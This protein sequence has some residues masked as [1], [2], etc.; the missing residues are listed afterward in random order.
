MFTKKYQLLRKSISLFS[1]CLLLVQSL[2][3]GLA[4]I[5]QAIATNV[6]AQET[7]PAETQTPSPTDTVTPTET[8]TPAPTVEASPIT[9]PENTP[10]P[11]NEPTPT[12]VAEV[13][14][15]PTL[16]DT[17]IV[18]PTET[19]TPTQSSE[20]PKNNSPPSQDNTQGDILDGVSATATP[21]HIPSPTPTPEP[22]TPAALSAAILE[23]V[24]V[25]SLDLDN[26]DSASSASLSTD[27]ADYAPTDAALITG[28]GL[29]KNTTYALTIKSDDAPATSTTVNV[30]TD[31]DG[32]FVYAYQLD[33]IYRPNYSVYLYQSGALVAQTTFTDSVTV[34]A[35]TGGTNIPSSK[36]QNGPSPAYTTLGNIVITEQVDTDFSQNQTNSTLI[37]T[38]P[39][40]WTFNPGIGSVSFAGTSPGSADLI[41]ATVSVTSGVI[42][43][44]FST[45]SNANKSDV[46]TI[47]GIQVRAV[48]GTIIPANGNIFRTVGNPGT[49]VIAGITNGAT[50]FGA[51]SQAAVSTPTNTPTPTVTPT[52]TNTPTPTPSGATPTPTPSSSGPIAVQSLACMADQPTAPNGLTCTANDID[53][54]SV[55]NIQIVESSDDG[56]NFSPTTAT[57]CEYPGQYIKFTASWHV[58]S[59]ATSRYNVGLWFANSGQTSALH[60]TC[61]ASTLP[62]SPSPFFEGSGDICGDINSGATGTVTPAI[63]VVAR[64]VAAPGTNQLSLPYC[65]SWDNNTQ[66]AACT[67][68]AGTVAGTPSKCNCN[69]GFTIPIVVPPAIEVIKHISP[70]ND[71]G[72]FNLQVNSSTKKANATHLDTTGKVGV[73]AGSNTFGET[74]GTGTDLSNYTSSAS[75]V[76]RGTQTSVAASIN[77]NTWTIANVANGQDIVCTITNTRVNNGSITIIKDASPNSAQDFAFTTTGTGLS[78]FNLDDDSD[79]TLSNTK[80]FSSLS[81]GNYSITESATTGWS[82]SSLS[83]V[84]NTTQQAV[85]TLNGAV[86]SIAL[87]SGQNVTCTYTN[88]QDTATIQVI[89]NVSPTTD[90]GV[91]NLRID[92]VTQA[93]NVGH[94]GDTGALTVLTT[95]THTV[96]ETA[97]TD[98]LL[99][100]YTTT[101]VCNNNLSGS[102]TSVGPFSVTKDQAVVCTFTNTRNTGSVKV[103]KLADT[104]G[105]GSFETSNPQSFTWSLDGA[106]TNAMGASVSGVTTGTH[107]VNENSVTD[108]HFVGWY[109]TGSTQYSCANPQ[110]TTLPISVTVSSTQT[111]EI[112]LCNARD[113]GTLRV[114]KNVDLNGD[115]D[116]TDQGE[117]GAT[118]WEW[119]A[120]TSTFTGMTGDTAITVPTGTYALTETM[121]SNFHF[122]SLQC[123]G[124]TLTD[125]SVA[126][127]T[128]ATVV[129]TFTN[130]RDTGTIQVVKDVDPNDSGATGWNFSISGATANTANDLQD[131]ESS[132]VFTSMTGA[133]TITESAHTGTNADHYDTTYSCVDGDLVV[134]TGSGMTTSEF[135]LQTGKNIVCTFTNT[136]K[137]GTIIVEKQMVGGTGSAQ[138]T[139]D[140]AG[141][142]VTNGGEIQTSNILPGTYTSVESAMTGWD[143]TALSCDDGRSTTP[144][145]TDIQTRTATFKVDPGETIVCTFTNTKRG[146]L[147]VYKFTD[148]QTDTTTAFDITATGSGT[149][150]APA[151]RT[152]TGG[153]S[154]VYEVTPGSY[155][156]SESVE[157][158]WAQTGNTCVNV[159][160][161]AGASESCTITNTKL[162][163]VTVVKYHDENADGVMNGAEATL[164]DWEMV[165]N[166]TMNQWTG[167]QNEGQ[168]TFS[169]LMPGNYTLSESLQDGWYQSNIACGQET[170]TDADNSHTVVLGAGE[171]ITC[172]VGNYQSGSIVVTKR[173]VN[174]DGGEVVDTST[175]FPFA[176][177]G[178]SDTPTL[179]DDESHTFVVAPGLHTVTETT[180]ENYDF[181]GCSEGIAGDTFAGTTVTVTSGQTVNVDCTNKQKKAT[182]TVVKDVVKYDGSTVDDTHEFE[183]TLDGIA[184][185][186][187][188][189]SNAVY[190]VNPGTYSGIESADPAYTLVTN[191][192]PATVSS[193]GTATI[194]IVNR[195]N[196]GTISGYKFKADGVTA[197]ANWLVELWSCASDFTG[198]VLGD[199]TT[200]NENGFYSFTNLVTGFYKV[201]EELVNTYTPVGVTEYDQQISPGTVSEN[202]NFANFKNID[203]TACKVKDADADL[204]TTQDQTTVS[205][206][207]MTL[208]VDGVAQETSYPTGKDG[209]YT[210]ENLGPDH[211]YGVSEESRSGWAALGDTSV[212]FGEPEDGVNESHTFYNTELGS[213]H[214]MKWHDINGNGQQDEI[215]TVLS[216]WMINLYKDN[217]ESYEL[218]D[219]M[220]TDSGVDHYGW[221]WFEDLYPGKYRVCEENQ[222]GWSQT[223]PT[224]NNGC[225]DVTLPDG[226]SGGFPEVQNATFGATY[227]FGNQE[228]G[229][230]RVYKYDDV[231]GNGQ[232][233]EGEEYLSGWE[234]NLSDGESQT[235]Q[236]T[237]EDGFTDF[238]DLVPG[239]YV[240]SETLEQGWNQ[241]GIS[242]QSNQTRID[243]DSQLTLGV[244]RVHA[245]EETNSENIDL[246]ASETVTCEVGNQYIQPK[247]L[248]E[249]TNNAAGDKAPGSDVQFTLTI[250]A[251]DNDVLGVSVRDLPSKGFAYRSG[252]WSAKKNGVPFAVSEPTYASPGT[253]TLGDMNVNDVIELIYT[254]DIAT[255]Q[256]SGTYRDLAWAAGTNVLSDEVVAND[257][258]GVFV[259]TDVTV[260]RGNDASTGVNVVTEKTGEVLG[261]STELPSTGASQ[262]WLGVSGIGLM[263][264][265]ASML[266]GASLNK[267][268]KKGKR[269][270]HA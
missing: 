136:L 96:S 48:D 110:G 84:D 171:N 208:I 119:Q 6:Q 144:S 12:P 138:F 173:V 33:G 268:A 40:N 26:V 182:I 179:T 219:T 201:M 178:S 129:C 36:A 256:Q 186:F 125:N 121:K 240:L 103:N 147:T 213:I 78:S 259:G 32:A 252:S 258:T 41:L 27:K 130:A 190:S 113:T 76:L 168:V 157:A 233:D 126:V 30:T 188:E 83:C 65:T 123:T 234:M 90:P 38:A 216:G 22:E 5:P 1:G 39:S 133:Y 148:P 221:Y 243:R 115:G 100:D 251:V 248:I 167:A 231:N 249:K 120:N 235:T 267:P 80:V 180:N 95:A 93:A 74:A 135:A 44:T 46:M 102:G 63:T 16:T 37:L 255:D 172:Y 14:V 222:S 25:T 54:A 141:T 181:V 193:N 244:T 122:V 156:I 223:Y 183:V 241:T 264:G 104:D 214:G 53:I 114:L 118:N 238:E 18:T 158:G 155:W 195:Q 88:T 105:N 203:I 28:T 262:F 61:S 69:D 220:D 160:V 94:G 15:T 8:T 66:T 261:A 68:P 60:G 254:A 117:T 150:T 31:T 55:D 70:T 137:R 77:A 207:D 217:G 149:I 87:T 4:A 72:L 49:G 204:E 86:A 154:Q 107:S 159:S 99:S 19:V 218:V 198:C 151:G 10:S 230:I 245:Q 52:S 11:T 226:N 79:N 81:S 162:G 175:E 166:G 34:T 229:M 7:T 199:S 236:T 58:L 225:H 73:I 29:K 75:C 127:T 187:A 247:L 2:L 134:A 232:K 194:T 205:S 21:T 209:C 161:A 13:S 202:N 24:E 50:S 82:L 132:S 263:L 112:T 97:G 270:L 177:G 111:T 140:V 51:L 20:P 62:T 228:H 169:D 152:I 212:S 89:K 67:G 192:S 185:P 139:G 165:L 191:D 35:A 210:W 143:L 17:P 56:V 124:G 253:W 59:N 108:Y 242:C 42:T 211:T 227:N 71:P 257:E 260:V 45:D 98:T 265:I 91:F 163:N 170:G 269:K 101:Y 184:K 23:H 153:S 9:T 174:P 215:G 3:P 197:I 116:Y 142:I 224:L 109:P 206:W 106:S 47:S 246:D 239:A 92:G 164:N 266:Y 57:E 237:G 146:Q 189:G 64:C 131:E 200:T 145:T 43:I 176:V 250:T 128:G 196:P 85:G